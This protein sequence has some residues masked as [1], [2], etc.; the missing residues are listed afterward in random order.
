MPKVSNTQKKP[1]RS[2]PAKPVAGGW[3]G[4]VSSLEARDRLMSE[5]LTWW[6]FPLNAK[7]GAIIAMYRTRKRFG[8]AL[9]GI[10]AFCEFRQ[11]EDGHESMCA[12]YGRG[13]LRYGSMR[14]L[15][16]LEAPIQPADMRTDATLR[17][18]QWMRRSFQGTMFRLSEVELQKLLQMADSRQEKGKTPAHS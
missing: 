14:V 16:R 1:T 9:Q 2:L 4:V 7:P 8:E 6:C 18:A 12:D 13:G 17:N 15:R 11:F 5:D 10:F 3:I